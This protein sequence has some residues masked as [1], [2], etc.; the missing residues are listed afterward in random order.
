MNIAIVTGA[1]SGMGREFVTQIDHA[2]NKL[3]EIWV[4]SRRQDK[5]VELQ[6]NVKTTVKIIPLDLTGKN[7]YKVLSLL[8]E[9][10]KPVIKM[11]VNSA[12]Y[13]MIGDFGESALDEELGMIELNCTALTAITHICIPYMGNGSR[14]IQLASS[15]AFL[16]QP[17]FAVYAA[18]KSYVLSFSRALNRELQEKGVYVTAVC[19]GPVQTEFFGIAETHESM[20]LY[21]KHTMVQA[22]GVVKKAMKDSSDRKEL[23]V[24]SMP[25]KLLRIA[26]KILPHSFILSILN[27]SKSTKVI[28]SNEEN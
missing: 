17:N 27:K 7:S 5:L 13:G 8:L 23:S 26:T 9:E 2:Y 4:I 3:N 16:P 28:K 21:K 10:Q 18:T 25:I 24:Y 1:S 15:A 12:G 14:I 22:L 19:P 11:L 6:K 20:A